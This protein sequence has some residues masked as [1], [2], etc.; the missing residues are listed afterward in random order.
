MKSRSVVAWDQGWTGVG[1][2]SGDWEGEEVGLM[3]RGM[4]ELSG[5]VEM[6]YKLIASWYIGKHIFPNLS[7]CILRICMF[8]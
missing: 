1:W 4:R 6:F 3:Q 5:V 7:N 8:I 2:G